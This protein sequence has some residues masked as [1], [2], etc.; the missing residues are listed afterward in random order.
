M[1]ALGVFDKSRLCF[2][3]YVHRIYCSI[4]YSAGFL[5]LKT[6]CSYI[7]VKPSRAI[8]HSPRVIV[9]VRVRV[10]MLD[11]LTDIYIFFYNLILLN[12][13]RYKILFISYH[14]FFNF[15]FS[16]ESAKAYW[17]IPFQVKDKIRVLKLFQVF[18]L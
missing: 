9:Y 2:W 3:P 4:T 1:Y 7:I 12:T 8:C 16:P 14:C 18:C 5:L 6:H 13:H 15:F 17:S 10:Y 11:I